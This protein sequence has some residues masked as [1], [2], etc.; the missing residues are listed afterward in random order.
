M[1]VMNT[2][3]FWVLPAFIGTIY[4]WITRERWRQSD[5]A[6]DRRVPLLVSLALLLSLISLG[7]RL[8]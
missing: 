8:F 4:V 5:S 2:V 6:R 3:L 7:L 1:T